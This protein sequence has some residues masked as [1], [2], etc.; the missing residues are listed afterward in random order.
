MKKTEERKEK[1]F[2]PSSKIGNRKLTET[3]DPW[4]FNAWSVPLS[5]HS[6]L[7]FVS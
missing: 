2:G 7:V 1:V 6:S 5:P 4:S 3:D